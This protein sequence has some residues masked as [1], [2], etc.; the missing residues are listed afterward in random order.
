M[1]T[2]Q[3]ESLVWNVIKQAREHHQMVT[4]VK[5]EEV[6]C[7]VCE[8]TFKSEHAL[9]VHKRSVHNRK[10]LYCTECFLGFRINSHW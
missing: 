6:M 10:S 5:G 1:K 3:L 7:D 4:H 2:Q 8:K 9:Q